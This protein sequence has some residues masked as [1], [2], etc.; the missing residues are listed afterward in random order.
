MRALMDLFKTPT[1][2]ELAARELAEARRE[3]LSAQ[4]ALDYARSM[5]DYNTQ[6]IRRLELR[7]INVQNCTNSDTIS[8]TN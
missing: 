3:L 2:D 4:S 1:A 7:Q 8:P 6:R 5:V